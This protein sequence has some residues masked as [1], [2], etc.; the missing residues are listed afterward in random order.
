MRKYGTALVLL[1]A[2]SCVAGAQKPKPNKFLPPPESHGMTISGYGCDRVYMANS[3]STSKSVAFWMLNVWAQY[4]KEHKKYWQKT[5]GTY[6]IPVKN[7]VNSNGETAGGGDA[8][9]EF[10]V[11]SYDF[12]PM[13]KA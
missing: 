2:A 6:E 10:E 5:Y 8:I 4:G 12:T 9:G 11:K 1:F 7:S 13:D 3:S